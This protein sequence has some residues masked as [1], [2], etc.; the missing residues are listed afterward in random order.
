MPNLITQDVISQLYGVRTYSNKNPLTDTVTNSI[1]QLVNNNPSRL[2]VTIINLSSDTIYLLNDFN[3]SSTNGWIL[4][5]NGGFIAFMFRDDLTLPT[6]A[7]YAI[8]SG[9]SSKVLVQELNILQQ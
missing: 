9:T 4:N 8:S 1:T 7:F 2:Q 3:P 5:P 6:E